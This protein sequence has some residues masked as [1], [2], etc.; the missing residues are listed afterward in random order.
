MAANVALFIASYV[1]KTSFHMGL[2]IAAV[3]ATG[4]AY[5]QLRLLLFEDDDKAIQGVQDSLNGM[6]RT[7]QD[8]KKKG[9][10]T[11][12]PERRR[13]FG[14]LARASKQL[15]E[16]KD[17][18]AKT[19]ACHELASEKGLE[20]F[21]KKSKF[22]SWWPSR[23]INRKIFLKRIGPLCETY[24]EI[25]SCFAFAP[26]F[27]GEQSNSD[28]STTNQGG[29][30]ISSPLFQGLYESLVEEDGGNVLQ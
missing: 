27:L 7:C 17:N 25:V 5:D 6:L 20:K 8:G 18:K 26:Q 13:D 14:Q 21:L 1:S 10:E 30:A 22:L 29:R 3:F 2:I 11:L 4:V 19:L 16:A 23:A 12:S 28:E 15:L 9:L 24:R